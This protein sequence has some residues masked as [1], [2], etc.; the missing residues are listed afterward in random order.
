MEYVE[1]AIM[2]WQEWLYETARREGVPEGIKHTLFKA[3][4]PYHLDVYRFEWWEV[5]L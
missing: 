5:T 4:N 1:G 2:D 3:E